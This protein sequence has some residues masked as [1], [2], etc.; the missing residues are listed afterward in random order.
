M[1]IV[2]IKCSISYFSEVSFFSNRL[3]TNLFA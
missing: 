3:K 2:A 1:E